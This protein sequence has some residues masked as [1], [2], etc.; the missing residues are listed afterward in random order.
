MDDDLTM[1][2]GPA[3]DGTPLEIGVLDINGEDPV[4]IHAMR[5]RPRFYSFIRQG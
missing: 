5:L 2:I 1:L 4:I 3:R